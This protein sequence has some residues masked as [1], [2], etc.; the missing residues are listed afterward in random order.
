MRR[1][2]AGWFETDRARGAP[3]RC[4]RLRARRRLGGARSGRAR[5][6]RR[7]PRPVAPDRSRRLPLAAAGLARAPLARGGDLRAPPRHLHPRRHVRRRGREAP[8]PRCRR[9]HRDRDHAG[10]PVRR[11]PRLGLRRRAALRAAPRLRHA[12][13]V[14]GAGRRRA[15]SRADGAAGRGLQPLRPRRELPAHLRPRLLPRRSPDPVGRRHRLRAPAG[16]PVLHRERPLLARGVPA[17]RPPPRCGRSGQRSGFAGARSWSRSPRRS[18][19]P[20]PTVRS[21]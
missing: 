15:R 16:A 18:A 4:L 7:R 14:Q 21:T 6:G 11:Q 1:D 5:T 19:P 8:A 9:H 17:R 20:S 2:A 13:R 10:R 3:G 12:G